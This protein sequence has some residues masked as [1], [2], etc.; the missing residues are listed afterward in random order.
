[1][2]DGHGGP[3]HALTGV[4]MIDNEAAGL[5]FRESVGP[6]TDNLSFFVPHVIKG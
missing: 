2:F 1:V 5:C 6:I 4:W 3:Y